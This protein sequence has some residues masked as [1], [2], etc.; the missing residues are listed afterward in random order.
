MSATSDDASQATDTSGTPTAI[1]TV[2]YSTVSN[3]IVQVFT[4]TSYSGAP[5]PSGGV[6]QK[7][8]QSIP[9]APIAGG[10]AGGVLLALAVVIAWVWWGKCIK[11]KSMKE[12]KE[13][14]ARLQV[15]ENTRGAKRRSPSRAHPLRCH[16]RSGGR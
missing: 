13:A 12:K 1:T 14:L 5:V 8:K 15:R 10:A 11:R 16:P 3:S 6:W 9:V 4:V 2:V 7:T